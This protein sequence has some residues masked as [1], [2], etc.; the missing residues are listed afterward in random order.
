MSL[1][2]PGIGQKVSM[3]GKQRIRRREEKNEVP[4]LA[5]D[6]TTQAW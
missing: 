2:C 3:A 1:A 5:R 4:E 6:N